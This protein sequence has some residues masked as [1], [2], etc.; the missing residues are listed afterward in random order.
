MQ[1]ARRPRADPVCD[2]LSGS[3]ATD[4]VTVIPAS[5]HSSAGSPSPVNLLAL[6]AFDVDSDSGWELASPNGRNVR[7]VRV[8]R[9][10]AE[11]VDQD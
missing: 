3:G 7:K 4:L 9:R 10:R 1:N 6:P 11:S 2:N 8:R 5:S